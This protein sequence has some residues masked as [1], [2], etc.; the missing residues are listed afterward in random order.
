MEYATSSIAPNGDAYKIANG[1]MF[2][3]P[4]IPEI[5][6][7]NANP[8]DHAVYNPQATPNPGMNIGNAADTLLIKIPVAS[9][10]ETKSSKFDINASASSLLTSE[11]D[12]I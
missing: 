10:P 8:V 6:A 9:A 4:V 3:N 11:I 12:P 7:V 1:G 5:I 2:S